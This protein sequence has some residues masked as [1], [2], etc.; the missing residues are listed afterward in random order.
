MV[1]RRLGPTTAGADGGQF[2]SA[3][4]KG[5]GMRGVTPFIDMLFILLFGMLALSDTRTATSAETVRVKLPTVEP[6]E[7][8]ESPE[9][10]IIVIEVDSESRVRL[11][12]VAAT[13]DDPAALDTMLAEEIGD[14]LP[15][16]FRIEIRAD[17][18]SLQGVMATLLQHLRRAGFADVSL[19]ALGAED[20]TWGTDR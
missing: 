7:E 16:E 18:E 8:G 15:E 9:R 5:P 10:R 17:A 19:L 14:A 11:D 6:V 4:M 1:V 12:G 2:V 13:I 3:T 20:A